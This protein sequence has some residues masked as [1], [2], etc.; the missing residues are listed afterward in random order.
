MKLK[1]LLVFQESL[2]CLY[3]S[4]RLAVP[5]QIVR[6]ACDLGETKPGK[7]SFHSIDEVI[8]YRL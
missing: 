3:S 1:V 5:L 2:Y 8:L 6:A 4:F 7:D